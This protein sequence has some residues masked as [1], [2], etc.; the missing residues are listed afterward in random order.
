[1]LV[2]SQADFDYD[3]IAELVFDDEAAFQTFFGVVSGKEA[4]ERIA[5]DEERFMVRER[6]RVVVV[7]E[8][9]VTTRG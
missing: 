5:R 3:A 7:G 1:M 9:V 4:A 2:G 8:G 6:M